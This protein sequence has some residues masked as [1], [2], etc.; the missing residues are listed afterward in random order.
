LYT[1][2]DQNAFLNMSADL[3]KPAAVA[4]HPSA[5]LSYKS[6]PRE[7]AR[8]AEI[9]PR[10]EVWR[11]RSNVVFA[12]TGSSLRLAELALLSQTIALKRA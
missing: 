1:T 6:E 8:G 12:R 7:E 4:T 11:L 3:G 10:P 5:T 2:S 9:D